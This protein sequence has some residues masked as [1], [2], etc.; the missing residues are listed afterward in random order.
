MR[1]NISTGNVL[2]N[3]MVDSWQ[4]AVGGFIDDR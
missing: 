2:L 4:L 1:A 3:D